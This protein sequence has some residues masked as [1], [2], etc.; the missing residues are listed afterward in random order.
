MSYFNKRNSFAAM[1]ACLLSLSWAHAASVA[2]SPSASSVPIT[3]A[4]ADL[5]LSTFFPAGDITYGGGIDLSFSGAISYVSFAPS[6]YFMGLD[7]DFTGFSTGLAD[8]AGGVEIHWGDFFGL[9]TDPAMSLGT[10]TVSLDALG[11]GTIGMAINN[12][13]GDFLAFP[14]GAAQAVSLS[15]ATVDV[16]DTV[17]PVPA[18]VWMFGSALGLLGFVR[19][20]RLHK[21]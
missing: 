9:I 11:L 21:A 5:D 10:V 8:T 17:V 15:G 6:G 4:T 3:D 2:V 7:P 1:A 19:R 12:A 18:A 20:R 13:F 16:T 14:G